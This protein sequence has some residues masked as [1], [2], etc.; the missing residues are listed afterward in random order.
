MQP[1]LEEDA[2][3]CVLASYH[4]PDGLDYSAI[5]DGLKRWGFVIYAGQGGLEKEMFRIS[6]MGDIT[7]YDVGRLLAASETVF[8]R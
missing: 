4:I 2:S 6:T 7:R 1:F 3:S 5:H 8:K